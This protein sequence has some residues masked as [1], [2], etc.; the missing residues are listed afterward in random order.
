[1]DLGMFLTLVDLLLSV[2]LNVH[3]MQWYSMKEPYG[4]GG[5]TR[6]RLLSLN[7]SNSIVLFLQILFYNSKLVELPYQSSVLKPTRRFY[8]SNTMLLY[9]MILQQTIN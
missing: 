8:Y 6:L 4:L 3:L 2:E 5:A 9:V 1:M 7:N